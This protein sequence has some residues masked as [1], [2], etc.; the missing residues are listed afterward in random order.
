MTNTTG[1]IPEGFHTVTP[2]LFVSDASAAIEFYKRA[3][4]ATELLRMTQAD[5]KIMHAEIQIGD[6]QIM[7]VDATPEYPAT[8]QALGGSPVH[9][10][11]YVTDPDAVF[12]QAVAAGAK[13]LRR[14]EDTDDGERRGGVEDPFGFT[15]WMSTQRVKMSRAELQR[16]YDAQKQG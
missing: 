16:R 10:H 13:P 8:P 9:I 2:Y 4:G 12:D 11:L 5:G 14:P 6:S 1:V 15:W 7:L 3:F